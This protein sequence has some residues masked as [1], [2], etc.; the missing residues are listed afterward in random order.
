MRSK[1]KKDTEKGCLL[2]LSVCSE[3][4]VTKTSMLKEKSCPQKRAIG[5]KSLIKNSDK[6]KRKDEASCKLL[7]K[8]CFGEDEASS[9]EIDQHQKQCVNDIA[10]MKPKLAELHFDSTTTDT[11]QLIQH[12]VSEMTEVSESC[13]ANVHVHV[14]ELK[15]TMSQD[16][17]EN[18]CAEDTEWF[19]DSGASDSGYLSSEVNPENDL[20]NGLSAQQLKEKW[21]KELIDDIQD[22]KE[23][24]EKDLT[25]VHERRQRMNKKLS[26]YIKSSPKPD[27]DDE[28]DNCFEDLKSNATVPQTDIMVVMERSSTEASRNTQRI[29]C[30]Q[31]KDKKLTCHKDSQSKDK[32]RLAHIKTGYVNAETFSSENNVQSVSSGT[33]D[34]TENANKFQSKKGC[35]LHHTEDRC[36]IPNKTL[37]ANKLKIR[38]RHLNN[39]KIGTETKTVVSLNKSTVVNDSQS[40][41]THKRE[42]VETRDTFHSNEQEDQSRRK[43]GE[44]NHH[45]ALYS[46]RRNHGDD[47]SSESTKYSKQF[48]K[49]N[50]SSSCN[51]STSSLK[52]QNIDLKSINNLLVDVGLSGDISRIGVANIC[53]SSRHVGKTNSEET[54]SDRNGER[55]LQPSKETIEQTQPKGGK[56][57][58]TGQS[59]IHVETDLLENE[60]LN[61]VT[62]KSEDKKD[63][64]LYKL[65]SGLCPYT[66]MGIIEIVH[67]IISNH[68][69]EMND[70]R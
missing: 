38:S 40:S 61:D 23:A 41:C 19:F 60:S 36:D 14:V 56:F 48:P 55:T 27:N 68:L 47:S 37:D 53:K 25:I 21:D 33:F 8:P 28:F 29:Q 26:E 42:V 24:I 18:V 32:V 50:H 9:K 57:N 69:G 59:S 16:S 67:Q 64:W 35:S 4:H 44:V 30:F 54:H 63:S 12:N 5:D 15:M 7:V 65:I 66:G 31:K 46:R 3:Q 6:L 70:I 58:D 17:N 34:S 1:N 45:N 52:K 11:G 62:S 2:N 10:E 51:K 13:K 43:H 20:Q 49:Q 22:L 39:A